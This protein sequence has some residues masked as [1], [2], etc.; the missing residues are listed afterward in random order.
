MR[1]LFVAAVLAFAVPVVA[2]SPSTAHA[3]DAEPDGIENT[4][5]KS[6][7]KCDVDIRREIQGEI[8]PGG[9]DAAI[10]AAVEAVDA[11]KAGAMGGAAKKLST[12]S[13]I[14]HRGVHNTERAKG[15]ARATELKALRKQMAPM[16]AEAKEATGKK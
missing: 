11:D 7:M 8:K 1:A 12:W 4:T 9:A 14:L 3:V 2:L 15:A 6:I 5:Y 16:V 10:N 13:G